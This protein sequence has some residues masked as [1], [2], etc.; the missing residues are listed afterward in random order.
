MLF[1]SKNQKIGEKGEEHAV[2]HLKNQG[3]SIVERNY[4][5][6]WGEIDIVAKKDNILHF[7]EVKTLSVADKYYLTDSYE[8]LEKVDS[9]KRKKFA[10]TIETY[11]LE[12]YGDE[13]VEYQA[14][15]CGVYVEKGNGKLKQVEL[16]EDVIL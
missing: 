15:A 4:H 14:D 3:F 1:R 6:P 2:S 9:S 10:R 5:K 8:A 16:L 12:H 11:L 7:I 13:E